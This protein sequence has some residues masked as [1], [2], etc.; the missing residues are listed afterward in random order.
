MLLSINYFIT[1]SLKRIILVFFFF[2]FW[3]F[4]FSNLSWLPYVS[5]DSLLQKHFVS[6]SFTA[7]IL[8]EYVCC[9]KTVV[10]F[11]RLQAGGAGGLWELQLVVWGAR[12]QTNSGRPVVQR[13]SQVQERKGENACSQFNAKTWNQVYFRWK[14][15][16]V[17]TR[18]SYNFN[19]NHW[20]RTHLQ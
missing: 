11:H 14:I 6:L 12:V 3:R 20:L 17:T 7:Y 13:G 16:M 18:V 5:E 10:G 1:L 15:K 19:N 2:F 9:S 4:G 8:V